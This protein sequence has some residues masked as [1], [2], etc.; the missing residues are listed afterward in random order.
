MVRIAV[1]RGDGIGNEVVPEAEETLLAAAEAASFPVELE[2]LDW[3]SER[4]TREGRGMPENAVDILRDGY[5]AILL[6]AI[7][8]PRV[9]GSIVQEE[10]LL[11]I[12][13][14]LDLYA[15]NQETLAWC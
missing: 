6:G 8:D 2:H 14:G 4:Y 10:I 3:G 12:R 11:G 9:G 7:G 15:K 13:F 5:G 1:I